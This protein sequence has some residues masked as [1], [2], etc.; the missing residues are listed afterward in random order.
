MKQEKKD[1][2]LGLVI[3]IICCCI[4]I[5]TVIKLVH[6]FANLN[7]K[8]SP[9][10]IGG[11]I[12]ILLAIFAFW[13]EVRKSR[14]EAHRGRKVEVYAIFSKILFNAM[15]NQKTGQGEIITANNIELMDQMYALYEGIVFYGSPKVIKTFSKWMKDASLEDDRPLKEVLAGSGDVILAMRNDLGLSNYGLT[16]ISIHQIYVTDDLSKL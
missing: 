13:R 8:V 9:A 14:K 12:T 7:D 16:N 3:L 2:I 4:F 1:I 10:I 6:F 5:F 15:K 11:M